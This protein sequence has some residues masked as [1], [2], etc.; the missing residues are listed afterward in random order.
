MIEPDYEIFLRKHK[1][2]RVVLDEIHKLSQPSEI[3][4]VAADHYPDIKIVATGSSTLEASKKFSDTLTGRKVSINL[5][6]MLIEEGTLFGN[7][8]MD[9][10]MLYGGLP[11]FFLEQEL[12]E[13]EYQDWISSY[14]AKD[15][16]EL[17]K[18]NKKSS[19]LMF[20]ELVLAQSGNMF[21]ASKLA[22]PSGVSHTTIGNYLEV[23]KDTSV[24]TIVRPFSVHA[25]T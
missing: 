9:H 10:R 13:N 25:Y 15:V 17:Y 24:A 16:Q 11:F 20:A 21:V 6:P 22:G 23:L 12:N 14:W 1:G 3:L 7:Q 18:L 19:F 5:L 4:K 2:K 8:D